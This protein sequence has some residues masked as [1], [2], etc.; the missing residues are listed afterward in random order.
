MANGPLRG[1]RQDG[2]VPDVEEGQVGDV[3]I[4]KN[5]A[6][7]VILRDENGN[8]VNAAGGGGGGGAD[9]VGLKNIAQNPIN[10]A[11]EEKQDD[12]ITAIGALNFL[13]DAELRASPVPV[14]GPL[15]DAEL[16]ATP[17]DVLGP[18]T[19][20]ELRATPVPVSGPLTDAE[21]RAT[22]IDVVG[23][24]VIS[25]SVDVSGSS[26]IAN[27]GTNLNTSLLALESGGNLAAAVTALQIL[28]DWDESDR[29]K[30]N[31]IVGQAGV[32]GGAGAV[33]ATTQ[34]VTLGS[35]DPAVTALQIIDDWDESDRAKVNPIAGQAG[36]QGGSGVV[37]ALT[38]RVVL[39][40]D[41][42]L[43]AGTN[44]LGKVDQGAPAVVANRWPVI[45]IDSTNDPLDL[46]EGGQTGIKVMVV[47]D[48]D[49]FVRGAQAHNTSQVGGPV[50]SGAIGS[51]SPLSV[52]TDGFVTNLWADLNGRLQINGDSSMTPLLIDGAGVTTP[53]SISGTVSISSGTVSVSGTITA[54]TELAAAINFS[55]SLSATQTTAPV[56]ALCELFNG[57]TLDRMRSIINGINT[58]GTGFQ[59]VGILAQLDDTSTSSVTEN[60][61]AVVRMTSA[62][63]LHVHPRTNGG[64]AIFTDPASTST[65]GEVNPTVT[66]IANFP[67]LY[68]ATTWDRTRSVANATNSTGTGIQ[69]VGLIAQLD[70][71]SP[72]SIT[73]NQFGNLRMSAER[74]LLEA[75]IARTANPTAYTALAAATKF[76]DK[77]GK[78]VISDSAPRELEVH[79]TT[80]ISN[81]T[82]ETTILTAGAS[83]VFHDLKTLII[84]NKTNTAVTVTIKDATAGTT[85]LVLNV[86]VLGQLI[87]PFSTPVSQNAAANNW[88]AT[89]S[90]LSVDVDIFV[91]AIKTV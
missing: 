69:A 35:D 89:L 27:A 87:I 18:L 74:G 86:P 54:D 72:T 58:T 50:V 64:I 45:L 73:E 2:T 44:T 61:F 13:T 77:L 14:S 1:I 59:G 33:S 24:V 80:A 75:G 46:T 21:L 81:S 47:G 11:T 36:V 19:D 10:P 12:I 62:R 39:A 78:T 48:N 7:H 55:D 52:I 88:T 63:G 65:D 91:Q 26:I 83:G 43:P 53:I 29:A 6:L 3:R 28:D 66:K 71:S 68:N 23:L 57:S 84:S 56:V 25:G 49:K 40:T 15:T 32:A 85:R 8:Y 38:Q 60:Q 9:P 5:R 70:D 42:A 76:L 51:S 37:T 17:V 16:R 30:V 31:I 41:V 4:S 79:Q 22:P 90:A 82:A 67:Y 34:R 20:T